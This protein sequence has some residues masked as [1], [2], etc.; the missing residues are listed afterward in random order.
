L[1]V[2]HLLFPR[3]EIEEYQSLDPDRFLP[4]ARDD[5]GP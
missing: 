3:P 5:A 2:Q 4:R 1:A